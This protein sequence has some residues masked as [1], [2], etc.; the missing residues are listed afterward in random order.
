ML[1][2]SAHVLTIVYRDYASLCITLLYTTELCVGFLIG[3]LVLNVDF[4]S[5]RSALQR[6]LLALL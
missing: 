3:T 4:N 1:V 2:I 6:F 5:L